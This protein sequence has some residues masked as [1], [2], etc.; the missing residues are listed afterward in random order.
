MTSYRDKAF[1]C[2]LKLS[3]SKKLNLLVS[4][5]SSGPLKRKKNNLLKILDF[6]SAVLINITIT[7][8]EGGSTLRRRNLKTQ[9]YLYG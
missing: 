9:F 3:N 6:P 8:A 4:R 2:T 5:G 7:F 1:L